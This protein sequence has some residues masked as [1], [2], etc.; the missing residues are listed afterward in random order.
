MRCERSG[1]DLMGLTFALR[2]A[3]LAVADIGAREG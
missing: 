2:A 3:R 1:S